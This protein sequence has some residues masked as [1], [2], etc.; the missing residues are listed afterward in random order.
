MAQREFGSVKE[1]DKFSDASK[2]KKLW[3]QRI[4]KK[5]EDLRS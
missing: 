4:V 5:L 2:L 3:R 1:E